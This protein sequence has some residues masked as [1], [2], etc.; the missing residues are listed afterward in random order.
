ML[1]LMILSNL[2]LKPCHGYELK[3]KLQV[4]NPNNNKIYPLLKKLA[5]SDCV[6]LDMQQQDNKPPRKV[7]TITEKGKNR[8]IELLKNYD[9]K[10][11]FSDDEFY[12]RVA[13][14]QLLDIESI[15]DILNT[16]QQ[17][18]T[19]LGITLGIIDNLNDFPDMAY[20]ILLLQNYL[21]AKKQTELRFIQS[22][23][24]KYAIED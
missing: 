9:I 11:A 4:L 21:S 2:M 7:Y 5:I 3:T 1:E 17:A 18:L 13:F 19:S 24:Q 20:D 14:F 10:N 16:R 23:K 22:L 15:K 6:T 8:L 12:I